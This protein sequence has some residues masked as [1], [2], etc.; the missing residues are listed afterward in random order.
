[1]L[2][3]PSFLDLEAYLGGTFLHPGGRDATRWLLE[4]V[5]GRPGIARALELGCGTGATAQ[6]LARRT[7]ASVVAVDRSPAM[8]A[9]ARRRLQGFDGG[10]DGPGSRVHLVQADVG[11]PLPFAD[12]YFDL[13]YAESVVALLDVMQVLEEGYRVLR[14]GGWLAFN[15]RIWKPGLTAEQVSAVNAASRRAF[16][17][18]AATEQPW[19]CQEWEA[20]LRG[21]GLV[22]VQ[23]I[24]I[25]EVIG[26]RSPGL[27]LSQR[28]RRL[29]RYLARL[30]A[31]QQALRYKAAVRQQARLWASLECYLFLARK[32]G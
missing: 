17:I 26:Q 16:G 9:A 2:N 21:A 30:R 13:V 15:E 10:P 1:M 6:L 24:P 8:L 18:P 28:W 14:P 29:R 20:L 5:A 25:D 3:H 27:H 32:P 23:A 11:Q 19:D 22:E 12:G 7:G 31:L 4:R